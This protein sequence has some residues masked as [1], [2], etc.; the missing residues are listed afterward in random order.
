MMSESVASP[1]CPAISHPSLETLYI[2]G[3]KNEL[4]MSTVDMELVHDAQSLTIQYAISSLCYQTM[5]RESFDF[6]PV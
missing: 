5:T 6:T 3:W 1:A 2:A 4:L